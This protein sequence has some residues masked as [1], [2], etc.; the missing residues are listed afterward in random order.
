MRARKREVPRADA[1]PRD[2]VTSSH[3]DSFMT[4]RRS[5]WNSVAFRNGLVNMSATFSAVRTN[6][7]A[8]TRHARKGCR[9]RSTKNL[10]GTGWSGKK[11]SGDALNSSPT[12]ESACSVSGGYQT[13]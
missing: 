8:V 7:K 10:I 13:W 1:P 11:S 5:L 2:E 9:V 12:P 3:V 4:I 6:M